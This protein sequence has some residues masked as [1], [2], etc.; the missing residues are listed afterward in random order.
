MVITS[1]TLLHKMFRQ[2]FPVLLVAIFVLS[3]GIETVPTHNPTT[4]RLLQIIHTHG[5]RTP[6]HFVSNDPYAD[7]R[8][9][10][11]EG[12]G[13]LNKVGRNRMYRVGRFLAATYDEFIHSRDIELEK[14]I[15]AQSSASRRCLESMSFLLSG[16]FGGEDGANKT[17]S[18]NYELVSQF[19]RPIPIKS[20]FPKGY[21]R[22]LDDTFPC[23]NAE[24]EWKETEYFDKR[25]QRLY[26][27]NGAFLEE[28]SNYTSE[29]IHSLKSINEL[30]QEL[31]IESQ[32]DMHW[33]KKPF[34]IWSD[35]YEAFAIS[36]LREIVKIFW[37]I[38]WNNR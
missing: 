17:A 25:I 24:L 18:T 20:S 7:V 6:S 3:I 11:P 37:S 26:E 31:F 23:P 13:Q 34:W 2:S 4:L 8:I 14:F 32:Y 21:D 29:N 9:F 22:L 30:Y 35:D 16:F 15:Y 19:W 27:E 36:K 28:I 38:K 33:W 1:G 5:D 12:I 10:W